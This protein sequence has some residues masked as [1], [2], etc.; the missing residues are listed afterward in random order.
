MSAVVS[1]ELKGDYLLVV[2]T[3][4]VISADEYRILTEQYVNEILQHDKSNIIIDET[5]IHY[6]PSLLLQS[7]IVDFYSTDMPEEMKKWKLAVVLH[8]DYMTFGEFWAHSA[9]EAGY[10]Y[11]AFTNM[12]DA[13]EFIQS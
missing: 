10:A 2:G 5:K 13:L 8:D 4:E 6:A 9:N 1:S 12:E 7:E 11:K 3:G